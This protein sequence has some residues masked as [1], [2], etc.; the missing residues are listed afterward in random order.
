MASFDELFALGP[1]S[2]DIP[3]G[4]GAATATASTAAPGAA[5]AGG[6]PLAHHPYPHYDESWLSPTASFPQKLF[7]MSM[8]EFENAYSVEWCAGGAA[9]R[10][11]DPEVFSDDV[12]PK[13][14]KRAWPRTGPCLVAAW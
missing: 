14:F 9:F 1:G 6:H 12:L 13:Y 10:V 7:A 2:D 5:A 8:L 11:R 4:L 3:L